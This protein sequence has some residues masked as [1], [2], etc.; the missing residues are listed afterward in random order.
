MPFAL[1]P[2]VIAIFAALMLFLCP[3]FGQVAE[4]NVDRKEAQSFG[5]INFQDKSEFEISELDQVP[6]QVS[7]AAQESECDYKRG[8]KDGPLYFVKTEGRRLVFVYCS[9]IVGTHQVFDLSDVRR[10]HRLTFPFVA[11]DMGFGSTP[12]PGVITWK[13]EVGLFEALSGTDTCPSPILRHVYRLG[14]T[15]GWVSGEQSFVLVRVD[16][17]ENRCGNGPWSTVWE[18]PKWPKET[19]VR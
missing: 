12:R 17:M 5:S 14:A 13:K 3:A 9:G 8:I 16:V 4:T 18:A 15:E 1:S 11:Q 19:I 2:R 6:P 10:P 7:R